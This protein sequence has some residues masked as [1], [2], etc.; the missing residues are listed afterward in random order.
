MSFTTH[1]N[2]CTGGSNDDDLPEDDMPMESLSSHEEPTESFVTGRKKKEAA[3]F[4]LKAK[5][6]RRLTQVIWCT[7]VQRVHNH[8]SYHIMRGLPD[9]SERY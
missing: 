9:A 1:I 4:L 7:Y 8:N 2:N 3:I 5:E 6:E